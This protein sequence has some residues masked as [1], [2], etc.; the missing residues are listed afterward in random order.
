MTDLKGKEIEILF[1]KGQSSVC[2]KSRG[3]FKVKTD[4]CF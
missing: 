2:L 3:I 1:K 4:E